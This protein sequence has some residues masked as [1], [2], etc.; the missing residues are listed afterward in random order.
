MSVRVGDAATAPDFPTAAKTA[1]SNAQLRRNV[2]H[3]TNVIRGKRGRVVSEMPDW[4]Q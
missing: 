1:L 2:R 4:Q 3:A